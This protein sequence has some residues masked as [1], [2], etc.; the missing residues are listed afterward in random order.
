MEESGVNIDFESLSQ[1]K[2]AVLESLNFEKPDIG[3]ILGSGLGGV[4]DEIEKPVKILYKDIPNFP[5]STVKGH[6]GM[7]IGGKL[8]GKKV[9]AMK[10]RFHYYE[11]YDIGK[12][13]Y[14]AQLLCSLGID[15]LI[16]SNA[17]GGVNPEFERGDIMIITDHIN[18]FP[19]H[20][21]RGRNDERLG[22]RFVDMYNV[23]DRGLVKFTEDIALEAGIKVRKGVYFGLQGPT[24]E[25]AAE[26]RM[27]RILGADAV[28]MS[29]VPE[30][31]VA[32]WTGTKV[33]G[34]SIITDLGLPDTLEPVNQEVVLKAAGEAAP[35]LSRLVVKVVENL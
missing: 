3:I 34:L 27:I 4:A 5:V 8:K 26:Y 24:F 20:P 31:I 15:T 28:G 11:G 10:G 25:T 22:P 1:S 19:E 14:G 17:A 12:V 35:K 2:K 16:V 21:L 6:E 30:V 32:R 23:Y 33:L 9:C 7:L 18:F 13:S 29:T